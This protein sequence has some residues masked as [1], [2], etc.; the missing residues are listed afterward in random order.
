MSR[1]PRIGVVSYLNAKPLTWALEAGLLPGV[2]VVSDVPSVLGAELRAGRLDAAMLSAVVHVQD[3]SFQVVPDAGCISA[4]G[5]VQSVLLFCRVPIER[6]RSVALDTSSLCAAALTRVLCR[7]AWGLEPTFE[8]MAPHL[9]SMLT[10]HDAALIIGDPGLVRYV[11]Q[12][13]GHYQVIDLGEAWHEWTG[14][15]FVFATWLSRQPTPQ[16]TALLRR[17]RQLSAPE[18]P[19]IA[20]SEAARLGLSEAVCQTYLTEVIHYDYGPREAEGLARFGAALAELDELE[21]RYLP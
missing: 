3:P 15:P 21:G 5:P 14:L 18:I 4:D 13:T 2:E 17:A 16:L 12:D 9:P 20:R 1:L 11:A 10:A 7:L 6:V 19:H 8:A